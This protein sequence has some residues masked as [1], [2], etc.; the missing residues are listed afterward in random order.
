MHGPH[1]LGD[2]LVRDAVV[3]AAL[4]AARV[5]HGRHLGTRL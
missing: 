2:H 4:L 1:A 3:Y 5:A